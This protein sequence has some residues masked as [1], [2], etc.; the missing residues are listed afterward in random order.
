VILF[1]PF[2]TKDA[3]SSLY[4]PDKKVTPARAGGTVLLRANTVLKAA[5]YG[6]Y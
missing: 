6:V 4:P 2:K 1:I 3:C 5:S